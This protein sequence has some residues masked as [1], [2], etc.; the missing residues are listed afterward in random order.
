MVEKVDRLLLRQD[1]NTFIAVKM[2]QGKAE[3]RYP[4]A[5]LRSWH[6]FGHRCGYNEEQ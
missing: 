5:F 2:K 3:G 4:S 1:C 6:S